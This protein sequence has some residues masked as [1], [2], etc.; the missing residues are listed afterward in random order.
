L[1]KNLTIDELNLKAVENIIDFVISSNN[2]INVITQ[3]NNNESYFSLKTFQNNISSI[4][5]EK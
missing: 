5:L 1:D 2:F 4:I 3:K